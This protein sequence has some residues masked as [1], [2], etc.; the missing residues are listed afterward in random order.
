MLD[1]VMEDGWDASIRRLCC[2]RAGWWR[3]QWMEGDGRIDRNSDTREPW[4]LK[5][6]QRSIAVSFPYFS[7]TLPSSTVC[8]FVSSPSSLLSSLTH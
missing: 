1:S 2:E 8:T 3:E 6:R 7:Q 4:K 5:G